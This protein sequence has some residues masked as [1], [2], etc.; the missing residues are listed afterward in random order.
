MIDPEEEKRKEAE[1][2]LQ[3]RFKTFELHYKDISN[4]MDVWDRATGSI[5][6]QMSP[7][8]KSEHEEHLNRKNK[9]DLKGKDKDK[10]DKEDAKKLKAAAAAAVVV[11]QEQKVPEPHEGD[12][13]RLD[14]LVK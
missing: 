8:E 2:L 6:R 10:K 13:V 4:L 11:E 3:Q 1:K 5:F 14:K 12:N 7:S 9:K